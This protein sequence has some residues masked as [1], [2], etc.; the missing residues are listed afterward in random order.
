M[1]VAL[2]LGV[3]GDLAAVAAVERAGARS[4]HVKQPRSLY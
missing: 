3:V 4:A 2:G 1:S